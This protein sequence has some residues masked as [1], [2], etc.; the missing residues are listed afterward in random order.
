LNKEREIT[1]SETIMKRGL[2][3]KKQRNKIGKEAM[4]KEKRPWGNFKIIYQEPGITIKIITVNPNSRLSLQSHKLRDENWI[5]LDGQLKYQKENFEFEMLEGI[6]YII[7]KETKHRL[8]GKEKGGRVLE[9]SF[10]KF[11]EKDIIRYE[12]DYGRTDKN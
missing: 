2:V 3:K 1:V 9:I 4:I 5:L 10:G 6:V 11:D 8:I 7:P 12:D